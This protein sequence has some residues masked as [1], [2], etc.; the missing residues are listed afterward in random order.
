MTFPDCRVIVNDVGNEEQEILFL[1]K[2]MMKRTDAHKRRL[3]SETADR[4]KPF[5]IIKKPAVDRRVFYAC[6]P[7]MGATL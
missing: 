2:T 6:T 5:P 4:R 1:A 3:S 7:G